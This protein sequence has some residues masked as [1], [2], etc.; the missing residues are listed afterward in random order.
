MRK[1]VGYAIIAGIGL[2]LIVAYG[3]YR[4][5][6][7]VTRNKI[8][9]ENNATP[10]PTPSGP[11]EFKVVLDKPNDNDVTTESS[12]AVSGLTKPD[13]WVIV[14]GEGEDYM[15]KSD[16]SGTF[17]Q[18]IDLASG[19]N[20]IKVTAFD[21]AGK[22]NASGV[23]VVYSSSFVEKTLP[24]VTGTDSSTGSSDIKQ[25]IAQDLA[26]ALNH[27]KAYIGTVT[28]VT[29]S[30]LEIKTKGGDILQITINAA[31][32]SVVNAVGTTNKTVKTTDIAIGDFIV[33][34]GYVGEN[35]VLSAQRILISTPV[36]EPKITITYAKVDAV[37]KKGL[38]VT[39]ATE[40]EEDTV[41]PDV[42]TQTRTYKDGEEITAKFTSID[43]E[44][45]IIYVKITDSK[46]ATR[47]RS[48]F[49]VPQN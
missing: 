31:D 2:G 10:S 8:L 27:P 18:T 34:M 36:T 33:A 4:I 45:T 7:N 49:L 11:K 6:T 38:T 47:V 44:D 20:Q 22:N 19:V 24:T 48:V 3:V 13:T 1:E 25:K 30:T 40:D 15:T 23:L 26:N 21:P 46:D 5:N 37:T 12:I 29:D 39:E 28:D 42:K 17:T 32:T 16:S 14:S 9:A 43:E 35:S 41:Q